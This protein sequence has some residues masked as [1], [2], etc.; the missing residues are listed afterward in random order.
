MWQIQKTI[1]QNP[2]KSGW[3]F[4]SS[5]PQVIHLVQGRATARSPRRASRAQSAVPRRWSR[6][7]W[8]CCR[9]R[10]RASAT[11][12][13]GKLEKF[14]AAGGPNTSPPNIGDIAW[15]LGT[16]H[17]ATVMYY[18]YLTTP[19]FKRFC[20]AD[21]S[22]KTIITEA[23]PLYLY[24]G[25]FKSWHMRFHTWNIWDFNWFFIHEHCRYHIKD[26]RKWQCH[27]IIRSQRIE[28]SPTDAKDHPQLAGIGTPGANRNPWGR[29]FC[30]PSD[31]T[32]WLIGLKLVTVQCVS[33][34]YHQLASMPQALYG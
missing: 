11:G 16:Q 25:Q 17:W 28:S 8:L 1:P 10:C 20:P 26:N 34:S 9:R 31:V 14:R 32:G 6:R 4:N 27:P 33:T 22:W 5:H 18:D 19:A 23:F 3:F 12:K 2:S 24:L 15:Y 30:G 13:L 7:C 21:F 29:L